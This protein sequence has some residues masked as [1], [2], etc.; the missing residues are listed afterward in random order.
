[1]P[2]PVLDGFRVPGAARYR[3]IRAIN[4]ET[5]VLYF[6]IRKG[7]RT[8][9]KKFELAKEDPAIMLRAQDVEEGDIDR[10]LGASV[11]VNDVKN[12]A[13]GAKEEAKAQGGGL[14]A[15]V[16]QALG[17]G[18]EHED[19]PEPVQKAADKVQSTRE[20]FQQS[21]KTTTTSGGKSD[22]KSESKGEVCFQVRDTPRKRCVHA[23]PL[24]QAIPIPFPP[25]C[26]HTNYINKKLR[27][28]RE[29]GTGD[30]DFGLWACIIT[31]GH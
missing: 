23:E 25:R 2:G 18:G 6:R 7:H 27:L 5:A 9:S 11:D 3:A 29:V 20:S 15:G 24:C 31:V 16:K 8:I 28:V 14:L 13:E 12:K 21:S 10:G 30:R 26:C 22:T 19:K 17:L 4:A 1:M